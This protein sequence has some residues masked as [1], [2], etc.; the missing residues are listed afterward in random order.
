MDQAAAGSF[1]CPLS[2]GIVVQVQTRGK[3]DGGE[4]VVATSAICH[5]LMVA[6]IKE[7]LAISAKD[8]PK[9][10]EIL[11]MRLKL[12]A[13]PLCAC[14]L[15]CSL[16]ATAAPAAEAVLAQAAAAVEQGDYRQA[17]QLLTPL[18]AGNAEVQA[19]LGELY[20][21]SGDMDQARQWFERAAR[22]GHPVAQYNIGMFHKQGIAGRQNARQA[23]LWFERSAAQGYA[24]AQNSLG[25]MYQTGEGGLRRNRQRA[26]AL[27]RQSAA[28]GYGIAQENLEQLMRQ[29][30]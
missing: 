5:S 30:F 23:R 4:G 25:V 18:A 20:Y 7:E 27:Y 10:Q 12:G 21:R 24:P 11:T 15:A 17:E 1:G 19:R 13:T 14:L 28:Q 29:S 9:Q 2:V 16:P 6:T 26:L 3:E 22:S 8:E